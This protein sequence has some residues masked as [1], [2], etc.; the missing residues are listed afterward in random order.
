MQ[1]VLIDIPLS[2]TDVRLRPV[3]DAAGDASRP[4]R[5]RLGL[6]A[7]SLRRRRSDGPPVLPAGVGRG[8]A[9]FRSCMCTESPLK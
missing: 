7:P 1:D 4:G 5:A 2:H 9:G 8:E 3:Y 6:G